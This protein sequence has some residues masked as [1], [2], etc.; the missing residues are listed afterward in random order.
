[1][2]DIITAPIGTVDLT[3]YTMDTY[4][5]IVTFKTA[6]YSFYLPVACGMIIAG[7]E[8]EAVFDTAKDIL[9]EMGQYFQ[10]K[11]SMCVCVCARAWV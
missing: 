9:V 7:I 11:T 3:R 10:V 5:R 6:Y 8:D 1:M 4:M 2:M